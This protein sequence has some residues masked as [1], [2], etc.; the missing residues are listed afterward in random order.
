MIKTYNQI[1]YI[2]VYTVIWD[3]IFFHTWAQ[4]GHSFMMFLH[5]MIPIQ[6]IVQHMV[7]PKM[8]TT[9]YRRR[10]RDTVVRIGHTSIYQYIY[11]MHTV[12]QHTSFGIRFDLPCAAA[13]SPL[14]ACGFHPCELA[15]S[16]QSPQLTDHPGAACHAQ[17]AIMSVQ[18]LIY[19][20]ISHVLQS[21]TKYIKVCAGKWYIHLSK[22]IN[23]Y[24]SIY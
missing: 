2:H 1:W 19:T 11:S 6:C 16:L 24:Q 17:I 21:T 8:K 12:H 18:K 9:Q 5:C 4:F 10:L 14:H 15:S 22:K 3:H 20:S 13:E 7:L 23:V